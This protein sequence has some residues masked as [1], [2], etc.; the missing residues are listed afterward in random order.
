MDA[1]SILTLLTVLQALVALVMGAVAFNIGEHRLQLTK[2]VLGISFIA[3]G[4]YFATALAAFFLSDAGPRWTLTRTAVSA[5]SQGLNLLH[6]G[7]LWVG[8]ATIVLHRP[9]KRRWLVVVGAV[10]VAGGLAM[11]LPGAF[12]LDGAS[13]RNGLRVGGR[14]IINTLTYAGAAVFLIVLRRKG[15]RNLGRWLVATSLATLALTNA[16]N[17]M[18]VFLPTVLAPTLGVSVWFQL[19]GLIGLLMLA[20]ALLVWLQERTQAQAAARE[21]SAQRMAY[22]DEASGLPNRHGLLRRIEQDVPAAAA[23]TVLTVRLHRYAL[24]ERNLGTAWVLEAQSRLADAL[25]NGRPYHQLCTGR[26]DSDRL[27]LALTADGSLADAEVLARRRDVEQVAQTLGHPV[28]VSFGYAVRHQ[29]ESPSTLLASAC[30]AQE[31][32]EAAG[33]HM[34]RFE[35]EQARSDAD[36][37]QIVGALYRALGEDQLFLE[38]QGI[39]N[40]A[41][42]AL[43]SVEAL[44]RWRHP[45]EG[46]LPPGRFLPAAERS[47]LMVD[48]DAWVLDRVCRTLRERLDAGLPEV[49]VAMNLSSASLMD[50]GLPASIDAQLRRNHVP[51]HLLE[52]EVTESAAMRDL[53]RASDTVDA[54]R[55]LGVRIALDDLGTG[56]S[57]LSHLRDLRADRLKIDRSF[58]GEGDRFGNAIALA[59]AALGHSLELDVVAEGIETGVQLALCQQN[60]IARVQGWHLHRPSVQWPQPLDFF[61]LDPGPRPV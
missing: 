49:P 43:D 1:L 7:L 58:M 28:G 2:Q 3:V 23:L 47:G 35:Y 19:G 11:A 46:V 54:L 26:V 40:A 6:L 22:F 9:L 10:S 55:A 21:E 8:L 24:L 15:R 36:E 56:Y 20:S 27:A 31:K 51:A 5:L 45:F 29:H 59:I 42:G 39:F 60:G 41:D 53:A 12:D 25:M 18:A 17:V 13:L 33:M 48:I 52:V 4:L 32:A 16:A 37:V 14:A 38:F 50:A 30:L 61:A 57:S 34:L 44:I